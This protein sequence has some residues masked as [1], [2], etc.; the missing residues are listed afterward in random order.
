MSE[1]LMFLVLK[2]FKIFV[3]YFERQGPQRVGAFL[4]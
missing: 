1:V 4:E 2:R 3:A